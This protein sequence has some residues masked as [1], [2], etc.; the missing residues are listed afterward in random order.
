MS[1]E[2]AQICFKR[3]CELVSPDEDP[4]VW[5]LNNGLYQLAAAL[6]R[7]LAQIKQE[8]QGL[9]AAFKPK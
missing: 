4:L 9:S 6:E 1:Y 7:D 8:L 3:N 2:G 5:N